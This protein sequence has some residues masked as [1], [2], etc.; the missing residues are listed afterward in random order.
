MNVI[1]RNKKT[2]TSLFFIFVAMF[3]IS[4][5]SSSFAVDS[6][7]NPNSI[8]LP[9]AGIGAVDI[10]APLPS[11]SSNF[12][13][14]NSANGLTSNSG[15]IANFGSSINLQGIPSSGSSNL[16]CSTPKDIGTLFSFFGCL[17][18]GLIP[19]IIG[20]AVLM[21]LI[22]ISQYVTSGDNEEKKEASRNMMIYGIISIFVM[23][24]VWGF[25]KILSTT[26]GF[27]FSLPSLPP[28]GNNPGLN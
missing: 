15:S 13:N 10:T 18:N 16:S 3:F 6:T 12:N 28:S 9:G 25:V 14:L 8:N 24:S 5:P 17:L 22:G 21:F 26:F 11:Q 7:L 4:T 2:I 1:K 27:N 23:V 19:V 20:I